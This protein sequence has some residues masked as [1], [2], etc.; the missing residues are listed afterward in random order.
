MYS[1]N[2]KMDFTKILFLFKHFDV[3]GITMVK[4]TLISKHGDCFVIKYF[5]GGYLLQI[6][7]EGYFNSI[8]N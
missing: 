8:Q 5:Q 7:L 4:V 1:I 6:L 3:N 2:K